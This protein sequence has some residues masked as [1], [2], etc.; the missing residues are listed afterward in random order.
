M[1]VLAGTQQEEGYV[2]VRRL[3][4]HKQRHAAAASAGA[5]DRDDNRPPQQGLLLIDPIKAQ[6]TFSST[7]TYAHVHAR[8]QKMPQGQVA[9]TS[10]LGDMGVDAPTRRSNRRRDISI[11]ACRSDRTNAIADDDLADAGME[12]QSSTKPNRRTARS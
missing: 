11:E 1:R 5:A 8:G 2:L 9:S 6:A 7:P 10:G 12:N 3:D 4:E